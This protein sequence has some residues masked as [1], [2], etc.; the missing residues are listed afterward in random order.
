MRNITAN[1]S[2]QAYN[3]LRKPKIG[4]YIYKSTLSTQK[5]AVYYNPKENKYIIGYRGT[6]PSDREDL[7]D[8]LT[9]TTRGTVKN[10]RRFKEEQEFLDKLKKTD[11]DVNL[12]GHSLGGI[13]SLELSQKDNIPIYT[14]SRPSHI[15]DYVK[16][17]NHYDYK[18]KDDPLT[19]LNTNAEIV[20]TKHDNP[21]TIL[22]FI[23]EEPEM[24]EI[25]KRQKKILDLLSQ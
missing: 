7:Q 4:D 20:E 8:D 25:E 2:N 13:Y 19:K 3:K 18:T 9:F 24:S 5:R 12:T 11:S 14:Y 16:K 15:S 22:N 6:V 17:D 23:D 10:T 1:I 21:H